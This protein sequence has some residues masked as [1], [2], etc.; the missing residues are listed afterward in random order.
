MVAELFDRFLGARMREEDDKGIVAK[1]FE[2]GPVDRNPPDAEEVFL[3]HG[4]REWFLKW[5]RLDAPFGL[6]A[7]HDMI[8]E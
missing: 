7:W 4:E 3:R 1:H 2:E 8:T 5:L 6:F